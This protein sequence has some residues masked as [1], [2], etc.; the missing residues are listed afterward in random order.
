MSGLEA[1]TCANFSRSSLSS[2]AENP[3]R[4]VCF[5]LRYCQIRPPNSLV[6]WPHGK[7]GNARTDDAHHFLDGCLWTLSGLPQL[8]DGL[9]Y[10]LTFGGIRGQIRVD[11]KLAD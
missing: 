5:K 6:R 8:R 10:R 11:V 9:P 1:S 2:I 4:A 7:T 3:L